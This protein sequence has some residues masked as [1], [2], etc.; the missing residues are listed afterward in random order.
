MRPVAYP[1]S[2]SVLPSRPGS[3]LRGSERLLL[4]SAAG[5]IH[6][7]HTHATLIAPSPCPHSETAPSAKIGQRGLTPPR[8]PCVQSRSPTRL[9]RPVCRPVTVISLTSR[10]ALA[11]SAPSAQGSGGSRR[12]A[13]RMYVCASSRVPLKS[14]PTAISAARRDS[15]Y[16][17]QQVTFI[18][19][20][21]VPL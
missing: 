21:H 6:L 17:L 7:S 3:N 2:T 16:R 15:C 13:P 14:G 18:S 11:E 20:T 9:P 8:H 1:T 19:P 5:H 4:P 10:R 12:P